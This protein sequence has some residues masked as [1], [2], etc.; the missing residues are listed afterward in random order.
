MEFYEAA[1]R[2]MPAREF[3]VIVAGGGTA[4]VVAALAAARAG[5]RTALI[6][7]KGYVGGIVTEGGCSLHSYFNLWQA[8]PGVQKRQLVRG[9]PDEIIGVLQA[10]GGTPGHVDQVVGADYDSAC[11]NVDTE[12]YKY[13]A[14]KMLREAGVH[15]FLDTFVSGAIREGDTIRGVLTESHGGGEAFLARMFIDSTGYGDLS[16]RAHAPHIEINDHA[17]TNSMGLAGVDL[18]AYYEFLRAHDAIT[19]LAW[20]TRD[21]KPDKVVRIS[22][23]WDRIDPEV[24]RRLRELDCASVMSTTHD[25]YLMFVKISKK[26]EQNPSNRDALSDTEFILRERQMDALALMRRHYPGF[27]NAFIARTS[28][29]L[30]IRRARCITCEYDMSNEEIVNGV[31]FEDDVLSYGFH[32]FA[33]RFQVKDGLSY[34]LPYRALQVKELKNLFAVGML[35]STSLDAHMSTRNTV[36]CMAQGQAAGTAAALCAV[37]D[38]GDVRSLPYPV[39]R[40]QLEAD[41]VW[42]DTDYIRK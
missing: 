30:T 39:L 15:V 42:F 8:F 12:I 4:G 34:G 5:A 37:R 10:H 41:G 31:H 9:I 11:T 33:P 14:L 16:A 38:I 17:V 32:D 40:A 23:N 2:R 18:E 26:M 3:D 29:T 27:A 22:G 36:C 13:V 35:I 6:E 28:P 7:A 24:A 19:E 21:G 20:G 1:P 25:N